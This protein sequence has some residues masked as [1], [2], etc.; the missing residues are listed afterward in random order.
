VNDD[1]EL[2][3]ILKAN[4]YVAAS[5]GFEEQLAVM[6]GA[7]PLLAEIFGDYDLGGGGF[8]WRMARCGF[9]TGHSLGARSPWT[10]P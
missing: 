7:S 3:G 5:E 10:K 4:G 9:P 1:Y 8:I 2:A 6:N